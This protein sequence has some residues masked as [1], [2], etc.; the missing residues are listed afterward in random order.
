MTWIFPSHGLP[1]HPVEVTGWIDFGGIFFV[2]FQVGSMY[3]W[4]VWKGMKRQGL[5]EKFLLMYIFVLRVFSR[6]VN[7]DSRIPTEWCFNDTSYI[8]LCEW[9][10]E[11][12]TN[13]HNIS[14]EATW[15]LIIQTVKKES[16]HVKRQRNIY[17]YIYFSDASPRKSATLRILCKGPC[18]KLRI[19]ASPQN[20]GVLSSFSEMVP[21]NRKI[22]ELFIDSICLNM[23][24]LL[25]PKPNDYI[26][27]FTEVV[28]A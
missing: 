28:K 3:K 15:F 23:D 13:D 26:I 8:T 21:K 5:S 9:V 11:M 6:L 22:F 24:R 10:V 19:N 17:I 27:E 1:L 12:I 14:V 4:F 25:G 18:K 16:K 2:T 7:C 20:Y